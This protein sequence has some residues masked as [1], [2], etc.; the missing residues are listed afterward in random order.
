MIGCPVLLA[1]PGIPRTRAGRPRQRD[2]LRLRPQPP[3]LPPGP[4]CTSRPGPGAPRL[5]GQPRPAD[6]HQLVAGLIYTTNRSLGGRSPPNRRNRGRCRQSEIVIWAGALGRIAGGASTHEPARARFRVRICSA[7]PRSRVTRRW[8]QW[9][10][11]D[12]SART[13]VGRV[14]PRRFRL[15]T[16]S[17]FDVFSPLPVSPCKPLRHLHQS[18]TL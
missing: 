15:H 5:S 18:S 3:S 7:G 11:R 16:V 12:R 4:G 17:S 14:R 2:A 10:R 1:E 9:R 13:T 6:G 8:R